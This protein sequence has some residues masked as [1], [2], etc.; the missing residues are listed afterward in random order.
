MGIINRWYEI[1][2]LLLA[3]DT[4]ASKELED[5][6]QLTPYTI[7]NNIELLN[8]ELTGIA[9]IHERNK[10]YSIVIEDHTQLEKIM[11]GTFKKESDFNSSS[12][13]VAFILKELYRSPE[14]QV[15]TDIAEELSVS[16]N[17]IN[18]DLKTARASL[19]DYEVSI[20]SATGKGIR[21]TGNILDKR[22]VY[23]NLA[24]DYFNFE[25]IDEEAINQIYQ[26]LSRYN[27]NNRVINHIIKV[28]DALMGSIQLGETIEQ[29]IA[30]YNNAASDT[31]MFEELIYFI[32]S[33]FEI[34]L[35]QY[36]QDFV[37][38]PFNLNNS[39]Q[40]RK[41]FNED[42]RY[43]F[44]IFDHM[45]ESVKESFVIEL[46]RELLY[47]KISN[48]LFHLINRSIFHVTPSEMFYGEV[49]K[50]YPFSYE[51][52]KVAAKS[53]GQNIQQ[54]ID[55]IELD[56]LTLYFEMVLRSASS[57]MNLNVAIISDAGIGTTSIIQRQIDSV[58]GEGTQFTHFSESEY[59]EADLTDFF[60]IFTSVPLKNPPKAVPVI[61]ISNILS[62]QWLSEE[63]QKVI[64]TNPNLI[65]ST[66]YDVLTLDH[67]AD[68][69][70]NLSYLMEPLQEEGLVNEEFKQRIID[71]E[72]KQR[73]VF[74]NGVAFPHEVNPGSEEIILNIG[75]FDNDYVI[76]DEEINIM[77]LLA[78][79][80]NLTIKNEQKLID[81]YDLIFRIS[82]NNQFKEEISSVRG[83]EDFIAYLENRRLSQ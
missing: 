78:A 39:G 65:Q 76:D 64:T 23:I 14:Y 34:S 15:I 55:A 49:E 74:D 31:Q 9:R 20:D 47:T 50:K 52:A 63:I 2:D 21:L 25:F 71:R 59:M 35:S 22:L 5:R 30:Y 60:V 16:R 40:Y 36:E 12:K 6:L 8:N 19:K 54:K 72:E 51:V 11:Y 61:K 58:I 68:Y 42:Y 32:E 27:Q 13:R 79:P 1:L 33:H 28:V 83:K 44:E 82:G 80:E 4:I 57:S 70:T 17:T 81:L 77:L 45:V 18:N 62:D 67:T 38:F 24:Q 41:S 69:M 10:N 3:R 43:L 26:I 56:Y 37:G 48:H 75:I 66:L 7:K 53:I 46:N 73:T 29:P